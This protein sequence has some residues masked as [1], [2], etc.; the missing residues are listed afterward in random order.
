MSNTKEKIY[1]T[2]EEAISIYKEVD[3]ILI[4]LNNIA[5]YYYNEPTITEEKRRAYERETTNFIDDNKI[6]KLLTKIRGVIGG[7]FD[8]KPGDDDMDDLERATEN[9]KYW[10]EP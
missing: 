3:Y 2:E 9:T 7:K 4:S 10:E 6:T 5:H 1:L 8:R